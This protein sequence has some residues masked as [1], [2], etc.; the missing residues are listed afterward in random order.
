M[1]YNRLSEEESRVIEHKGTE[2]PYTG[3]YDNF[4]NEGVYLCRRCNEPLYY[5][6]DK[7]DAGCGWPSFDNEMEGKVERRK[8]GR[9]MEIVCAN[10]EAHL[11]HVFEGEKLTSKNTRHCV[12]SVSLR[13]IPK[14]SNDNSIVMGGG[15]FWCAD[16][17]FRN[18]WG[19]KGVESGYAGGHEKNPTYD[20]V[21]GGDTGHEL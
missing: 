19:V 14:E 21:S 9:Q 11:G 6:N 13:F 15:C 2:L 18:V 8:D 10:C 4:Y 7:F 3:E 5:S 20:S 1:A 12:N 16:A 17:V